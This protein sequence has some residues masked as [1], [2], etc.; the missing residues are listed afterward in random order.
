[1]IRHADVHAGAPQDKK[2]SSAKAPW[3]KAMSIDTNR[4]QVISPVDSEVDIVVEKGGAKST[5]TTAGT[6]KSK[7]TAAAKNTSSA[8]VTSRGS[9]GSR[10][11]RPIVDMLQFSDESVMVDK[12]V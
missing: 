7:K 11:S 2:A 8:S 5:S 10:G 12:E 3:W 6:P 1:M 9:R 4:H